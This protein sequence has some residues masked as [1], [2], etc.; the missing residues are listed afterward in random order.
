MYGNQE[1]SRRFRVAARE[2]HTFA[3]IGIEAARQRADQLNRAVPN[4][5]ANARHQMMTP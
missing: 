2:T 5:T 4:R 1:H 3:P